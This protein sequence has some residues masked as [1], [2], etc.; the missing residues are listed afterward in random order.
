MVTW[1][2]V[3]SALAVATCLMYIVSRLDRL[4]DTVG[5]SSERLKDMEDS[6]DAI[7]RA[8]GVPDDIG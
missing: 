8:L 7:R 5:R 6:I 4:S 2:L 1:L 3:A